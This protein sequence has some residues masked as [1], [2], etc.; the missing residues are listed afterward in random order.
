MIASA[1]RLLRRRRS[2]R[3]S[4][5]PPRSPWPR[6]RRA[7]RPYD[8]NGDGYTDLAIGAPGK[9]IGSKSGAGAVDVL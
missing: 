5:R 2:P 4:S 8:F 1:R 9:S 6:L 3:S 7:A